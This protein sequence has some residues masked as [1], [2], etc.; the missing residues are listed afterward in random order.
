MLKTIVAGNYFLA[1]Y[2]GCFGLELQLGNLFSAQIEI[3]LQI[4]EILFKREKW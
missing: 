4:L 3:S 2:P 1:S